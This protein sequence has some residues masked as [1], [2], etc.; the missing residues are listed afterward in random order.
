[1]FKLT[2]SHALRQYQIDQVAWEFAAERHRHGLEDLAIRRGQKRYQLRR[3]IPPVASKHDG[4]HGS[5]AGGTQR[6]ESPLIVSKSPPGQHTHGQRLHALVVIIAVYTVQWRKSLVADDIWIRAGCDE[7]LN[8]LVMTFCGCP[9]QWRHSVGVGDIWIRAG[10]DE[11]LDA[12]V[13]AFYGCPVQGWTRMYFHLTYDVYF[14][15]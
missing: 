6:D 8:A 2:Q 9:V 5:E 10:C 11:H 13:V 1:M 14:V 15:A 4:Q 7:H 12:L 3:R